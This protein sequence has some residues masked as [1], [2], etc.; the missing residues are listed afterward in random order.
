M[1]HSARFELVKSYYLAGTWSESRVLV[2]VGKWITTDEAEEILG[3][4]T[5]GD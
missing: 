5:L 2:A 3:K 4:V 1:E